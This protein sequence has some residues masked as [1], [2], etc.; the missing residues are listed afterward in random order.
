MIDYIDFRDQKK[1]GRIKT[2]L[3]NKKYIK[4]ELIESNYILSNINGYSLD[5]EQRLAIITDECA[6]LIIAGAGS[7]KSLTMVGKIRYLIERK[8]IK[9]D[10]ILCISF[11]NDACNNLESNIKKNY[12]YNIKVYTFHKLALE[13]LKRD[14]YNILTDSTLKYIIDEYFYMNYYNIEMRTK[15]KKVLC[16][17]DT[18]YKLVL[19][20]KKL[21]SLKKLIMT[22]INLFKTNNYKLEDFIKMKVNK[23]LM[24]I[25]IDIY[26]LYEEELK[27]T[28]SI[29]FNDMILL[30]T[31]HIKKYGI[32]DYKYIIVDEYQD[33]SYIRYM[34]LRE[35]I[36]KTGSKIVC[37][38]DDYQSIYRFNGCNINMFL[39]FK[40]YFKY[41]KIL[42]IS[43]TYRNSQ[44][45]INVC[46]K[47][48]MKN[49]RQLYKK[50]KS[51]KRNTKPIKIMYGSNLKRLI[52][53]ALL[54]HREILIL[55]RN[56]HD[57]NEYFKLDNNNCIQYKGIN[58]KYMTIHSSKGLEAECV[59]IINL[60]DDILGIPSKIPESKV[61]K[62]VNNGIDIYPYEEERR[63][64]Y[65]AMTRSKSDVY[66]LVNKSKP[67]MFVK[68][69]IVDSKNYMEYI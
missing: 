31:N 18:P 35:I 60:K 42:R 68:E 10:Q 36:N 26:L 47:F 2:N 15:I 34:L 28:N 53:I 7:G 55:G 5:K 66:L 4:K 6:N 24:R 27:S 11:T 30:A 8:G 9:E 62:C 69:L 50:L 13:I 63:L 21:E 46:G 58:I 52:D 41:A 12:K 65:V 59:I 57:I 44:E 37:V 43:N 49:K 29:D 56:N 64:F 14:Q 32:K 40:K 38:G 3:L 16:M 33:T 19:I 22:F 39:N 61:L 20:S 25:I 17:I 48:I 54:S 23:D 67:S 45:L 1:Y 51:S